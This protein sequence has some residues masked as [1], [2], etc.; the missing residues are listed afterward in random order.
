[1]DDLVSPGLPRCGDVTTTRQGGAG[2]IHVARPDKINAMRLATWLALR[3]HVEAC[4][5]HP[6]VAV[7]V[8]RGAGRH[9]GAGNDIAALSEFPGHPGRALEFGMAWA[10]AIDAVANCSK[11]VIM[12]IDGVCYGAALA[13]ALAG[14]VRIASSDAVF[15]IPVAKL[16]ALY[17]RSDYQ[18]LVATIGMSQSKRL[19]YTADR[20]VAGEALRIGLVDEVIAAGK[21]EARLAETVETILSRS[22]F[23]LGQSKAMLRAQDH[24]GVEREDGASLAAFAASTQ[25]AHFVEGITAFLERRTVDF[26]SV[27]VNRFP[28]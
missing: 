11:P 26:R 12:A 18:R 3:L 28:Y 16:G 9:F 22:A 24:G 21:F 2:I 6:D 19:I 8:L 13:L 1:M 4:E 27:G 15:S 14:D 17:L 10:N 20:I 23:T 5:R 25:H 7:I